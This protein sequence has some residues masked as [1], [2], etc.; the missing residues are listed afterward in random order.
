MRVSWNWLGDL[1][2]LAGTPREVAARLTMAG[3]EVETVTE[4]GNAFSG[5]VVAEVLARR[6]HPKSAKLTIVTVTDGSGP[7]EVVC[8]APNVP[9]AGGK[10]LWA[11]PGGKLPDGREAR[12]APWPAWIRRGYCARRSSWG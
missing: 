1:V 8:G 4:L 5:V 11:R 3:L 2:E 12:D 7:T 9:D 10:V 6:P